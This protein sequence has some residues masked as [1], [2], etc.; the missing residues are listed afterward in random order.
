MAPQ[1]ARSGNRPPLRLPIGILSGAIGCP[2]EIG[3]GDVLGQ[4]PSFPG[5]VAW[6]DVMRAKVTGL[7]EPRWQLGNMS[8][9]SD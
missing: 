5:W 8:Q 1:G 3:I 4:A 9:L 2:V 7:G 6:V